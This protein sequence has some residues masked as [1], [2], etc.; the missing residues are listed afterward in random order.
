M[1][2]INTIVLLALF[3]L[4]IG[5][6]AIHIFESDAG[7]TVATRQSSQHSGE[8]EKIA[9][10]SLGKVEAHNYQ[11]M[12]FTKGFIQ[13]SPDNM[14]L[15]V[16]TENGEV[17]LLTNTGK[18]VWRK[19][20]GLGKM[21]ALEFSSD[22]RYILIGESSQQ[23]YLLCLDAKDGS[24]MWRQ[25]SVSELGVEIKD[26]TYPSIVAI[27]TDEQ[28][29]IFAVGQRYIRFADGRNEYRGRIYKF[30]G[31][32]KRLAMFPADH[33]LDAWVSWVSVDQKGERAVFGTANWDAIQTNRY[34][35]N[36]YCLDGSLNPLWST[37][38]P[39]V[40][41]YQ[42][43]TMRSSPEISGDGRY[44]AGIA[45][46]GRCFLYD[47]E[48]GREVWRR[49]LSEPQKIS[50][51][52]MNAN[53]ANV[54]IVDDHFIFTTGNTYN[55]ANWQLPTPV[56]H[57]GSNSM[58]VFNLQGQLVNRHR[59]GGMIEQIAVSKKEAAIAVGR[60]VRTKDPG[61]H[62]LYITSLPGA[63]MIDY[64]ATNGPCVG[65]AISSDGRYTAAVEAPLQLD[66]GQI[67]GEYKLVLAQSRN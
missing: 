25:A 3:A 41:P 44:V 34:T 18:T 61:V 31:N 30:D 29:R 49:N 59:F 28:G 42:N 15:A 50:G 64:I 14:H 38:I 26:K 27:R 58:F 45:S 43:T 46:D 60:N 9:E 24:E 66:D 7:L 23:G 47:G 35:D 17:L 12:G 16:G 33:N 65:S 57:P 37:L 39:P 22:S 36:M 55:R 11:R 4:T 67:I 20:I 1:R 21:S 8:Y 63:Q 5:A 2:K 52:Y 51:I 54:Q 56:E 53:G 40:Y 13:F 32:G 10:V 6:L 62:G 48:Q 19:N